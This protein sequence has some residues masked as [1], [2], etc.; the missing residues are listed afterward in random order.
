MYNAGTY[1]CK[2]SVIITPQLLPSVV[3]FL[4]GVLWRK[5]KAITSKFEQL[6]KNVSFC[7]AAVMD[8]ANAT[9]F[10]TNAAFIKTDQ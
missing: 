1:S 6:V 9:L 4:A 2:I 3:S 7:A 5:V 8:I 10:T